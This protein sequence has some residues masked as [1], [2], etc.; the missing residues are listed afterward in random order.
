MNTLTTTSQYDFTP[1]NFEQLERFC[2]HISSSSMVP[3]DYISK[4]G[5]VLVA[6]QMGSELGLKPMQALQN[7]SVING[8]PSVWGDALLALVKN[9]PICESIEETFNEDKTIATC[10]VKRKG[11]SKPVSRQFSMQDAAKA[12]LLGK[13]NW[14]KYPTRMLQLRAR[15]WALRDV[16]PDILCGMQVAE[17]QQDKEYEQISEINIDDINATLKPLNLS[18]FKKDGRLIVSGNTYN[19]SDILKK[20]GFTYEDKKWFIDAPIDLTNDSQAEVEE[21]KS[22]Q[23]SEAVIKTPVETKKIT[24]KAKT[25]VKKTEV[26]T[27]EV[28]EAV[29]AKVTKTETKPVETTK[30]ETPKDEPKEDAKSTAKTVAQEP[31]DV[32]TVNNIDEL[33]QYVLGL[34]FEF[35]LDLEGLQKWMVLRKSGD[36]KQH[37]MKLRAVGFAN[38]DHRGVASNITDLLAKVTKSEPVVVETIVEEITVEPVN[39]DINVDDDDIAFG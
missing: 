36:I 27:E 25:T 2:T 33:K 8:R 39:N 7:I 34:G 3:K 18:T 31:V 32:P 13:D 5:N 10:T 28:K 14:K 21:A 20:L 26:K 38:Y 4:P 17:E 9:H 19:R 23:V 16:F 15:A 24:K 11:D 22:E 12:G 37:E 1:T 6:V 35:D 29:K 30:V